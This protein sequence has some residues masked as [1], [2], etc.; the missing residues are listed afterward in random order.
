MV[1][2]TGKNSFLSASFMHGEVG[3]VLSEILGGP[4]FFKTSIQSAYYHHIGMGLFKLVC[5]HHIGMDVFKLVLS[6]YMCGRV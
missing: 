6:S 1:R 5:Y 4:D 2:C 3:H